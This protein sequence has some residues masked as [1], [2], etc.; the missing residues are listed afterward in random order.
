MDTRALAEEYLHLIGS[1]VGNA[2]FNEVQDYS[3]GE[4]MALRV[5]EVADAEGRPATPGDLSSYLGLSTARIAN[6]LK[7]LERKGLATRVHD[8][9]DRRRVFVSLTDEGRALAHQKSQEMA[10]MAMAFIEEMGEEDASELI[11]LLGRT[12]DYHK[13]MVGERWR[14]PPHGPTM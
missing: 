11:R 10:A 12:I 6:L 1:L 8:D 13:R 2:P 9:A 5:L 7:S 3:R 4:M 14:T